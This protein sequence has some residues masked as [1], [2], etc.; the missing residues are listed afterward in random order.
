[1]STGLG[2]VPD[3]NMASRVVIPPGN[4]GSAYED[5]LEAFRLTVESANREVVVPSRPVRSCFTETDAAT[6]EFKRSMCLKNWPHR[7]FPRSKRLDVIITALETFEK[8]AWHLTRS[9]VYVNYLVV[10]DSTAC[11]VQSLHYDFVH[12]GQEYHP[13]FHVELSDELIADEHLQDIRATGFNLELKLPADP[14]H[15]WVT[16][17]IPTPEMTLASVLY[18]LVA[19][20]LG[21]GIFRE[22]AGRVHSIQDRMPL[23]GFDALKASIQKSPHFKSSHW[24]AHMG[25]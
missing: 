1:M 9:T 21:P 17:R 10:A 13:F 8:P 5:F 15:C 7:R 16:T 6:A 4:V 14:S 12:G 2:S 24:F 11:L 25:N 19:D 20:H 18:C 3:T 23:L 22:F